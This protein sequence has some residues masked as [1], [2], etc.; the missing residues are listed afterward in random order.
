MKIRVLGCQGGILPGYKSTAFLINDGILIDSGSV[1][2]ELQIEEQDKVRDIFITHSHLDH[3]KDIAFFTDNA[4]G[5]PDLP[6]RI[7]GSKG[8]ISDFKKYFFNGHTWPDFTKIYSGGKPTVELAT[9]KIKE[10]I[11]IGDL[12]ISSFRTNHNMESVG[13]LLKDRNSSVIFSGD[14]G[15]TEELWQIA[16]QEEN[17]KALFIETTLPNDM[18]Q[19]ADTSAHLTP[20]T[21]VEELSKLKRSGFPIYTYHLKPYYIDVL[22]EEINAIGRSDIHVLKNGQVLEF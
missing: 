9:I 17:L 5:R 12:K 11:E 1:V 6:I 21:L 19:I 16:N 14:T 8:T 18:Q 7:Y 20:N 13:Y 2:S 15:P 3:T 4:V 22:T 10:N